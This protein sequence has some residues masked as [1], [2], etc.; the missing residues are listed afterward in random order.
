MIISRSCRF[1]AV[2]LMTATLTMSAMS[3]AIA[4]ADSESDSTSGASEES[5]S[6]SGRDA[7]TT[8]D[9]NITTTTATGAD[10][11]SSTVSAQTYTSASSSDSTD[12]TSGRRSVGGSVQHGPQRHDHH[13]FG[14]RP[15]LHTLRTDEHL[16]VHLGQHRHHQREFGRSSHHDGCAEPDQ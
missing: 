4:A 6:G 13:R 5:S 2:C 10:Q 8:T 1:A 16:H 3:G 11:P 9:H 7:T 15:Q 12:T 14:D